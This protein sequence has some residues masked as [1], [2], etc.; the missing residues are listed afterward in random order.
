MARKDS[1]YADHPRITWF[2]LARTVAYVDYTG[3]TTSY[4]VGPDGLG[5]F[6]VIPPNS[7]DGR[8]EHRGFATLDDGIEYA[9]AQAG[10]R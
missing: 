10:P 3:P 7:P 8:D 4:F 1:R 5:A 9:L 6:K 2:G